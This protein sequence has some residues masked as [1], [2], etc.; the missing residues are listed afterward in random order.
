MIKSLEERERE[1]RRYLHDLKE[2]RSQS[3]GESSAMYTVLCMAVVCWEAIRQTTFDVEE[4]PELVVEAEKG[5]VYF[6]YT[7]RGPK[8]S[9]RFWIHQI[10]SKIGV[11][12]K[13][14]LKGE[15]ECFDNDA[16]VGDI[17]PRL[18]R[19]KD[20]VLSMN[21]EEQKWAAS[22]IARRG[23]E[24][25]SPEVLRRLGFD[26]VVVERALDAG[27]D[28]MTFGT[29]VDNGFPPGGFHHMVKSFGLSKGGP[30]GIDRINAV[31]TNVAQARAKGAA[32]RVQQPAEEG[33][34]HSM[35]RRD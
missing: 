23:N 22:A 3:A 8:N 25:P 35:N 29:A 10:G 27:L 34:V 15:D 18:E 14:T 5:W 2:S 1:F 32:G 11:R 19:Y 28:A 26:I 6:G 21:D 7:M 13:L 4:L 30:L 33:V 31:L 16:H 20:Y 24:M 9:F 12:Y 17:V